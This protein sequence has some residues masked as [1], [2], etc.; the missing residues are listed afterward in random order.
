[1][2]VAAGLV[3]IGQAVAAVVAVAAAVVADSSGS[4]RIEHW[5]I[6]HSG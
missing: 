6:V 5:W 3:S 2:H 4:S 1:M